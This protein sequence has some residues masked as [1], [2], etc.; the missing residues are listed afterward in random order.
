MCQ[1]K[2][3]TALTRSI[4]GQLPPSNADFGDLSGLGVCRAFWFY[5]SLN[6]AINHAR[7]PV[8]QDAPI[9]RRIDIV[10]GIQMVA[11]RLIW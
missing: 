8:Q 9:T 1:D 4:E 11:N 5:I 6:A 3:I 2:D 7:D 10:A